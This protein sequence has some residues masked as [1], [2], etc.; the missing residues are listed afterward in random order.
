M[1]S[2]AKDIVTQFNAKRDD[3]IILTS[4]QLLKKMEL[5]GMRVNLIPMLLNDEIKIN[6]RGTYIHLPFKGKLSKP[7][8]GDKEFRFVVDHYKDYYIF[9]LSFQTINT[10]LE[11]IVG[12]KAKYL[13]PYHCYSFR[14][15][16]EIYRITPILF[17]LNVPNKK[18]RI[19]INF[20]YSSEEK[21]SE[22]VLTTIFTLSIEDSDGEKALKIAPEFANVNPKEEIV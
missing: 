8:K 3:D 15:D 17:C 1:I 22:Y 2:A 18:S 11:R 13:T 7:K 21:E 14:E 12:K 5:M 20:L 4:Q 16:I 9:F 19:I 6:K 10:V